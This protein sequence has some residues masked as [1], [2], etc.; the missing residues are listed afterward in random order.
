MNESNPKIMVT[1]V[2]EQPMPNLIPIRHLKP[3]SVILVRTDNKRVVEVSDNLIKLISTAEPLVV[4]P[5]DIQPTTESMI[6]F[7][8]QRGWEANDLLFNLTGGTKPMAFAAYQVAAQLGS[9]F[10]YLQSEGRKSIIYWYEFSPGAGFAFPK[11]DEIPEVITIDDYLK[12]HGLWDYTT[13]PLTER[14]ERLVQQAL[15]NAVNT[16]KISELKPSV[17]QDGL[18]MD[19]VI[20]LKNQIGIAEIKTGRAARSIIGINQLNTASE[21]RFLGTYI[22][23]FLILDRPLDRNNQALAEAHRINVIVLQN[24][25]TQSSLPPEDEN[26]LINTIRE[27][28]RG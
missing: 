26:M 20:R 17:W 5:Y 11:K 16:G 13:R 6:Q 19:L 12:A 3:K 8:Q 15:E 23:K 1:L 25:S 24:I 9:P 2:G 28:L 14:F 10:I 18:Q 21:Q 4:N 7:I 27:K 22:V